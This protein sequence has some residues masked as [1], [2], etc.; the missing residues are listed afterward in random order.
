M[1]TCLFVVLTHLDR[2]RDH[3]HCPWLLEDLRAADWAFKKYFNHI[4]LIFH[5]FILYLL[6]GYHMF[7]LKLL[8]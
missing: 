2:Q 1:V 6:I 4:Y 5:I 7:S 3:F 8:C